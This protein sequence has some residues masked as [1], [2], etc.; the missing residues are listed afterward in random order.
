MAI[1]PCLMRSMNA[2][3]E[4]THGRGISNTCLKVCEAMERLTGVSINSTEQHVE[5]RDSHKRD[6]ETFMSLIKQHSPWTESYC[7]RSL[8]SGVIG[9]KKI[10]CHNALSDG[11][12]AMKTMIGSNFADVKLTRKN[13]V[14]PLTVVNKSIT[15]RNEVVPVNLQQLFMHIVWAVNNNAG[16]L[17]YYLKYE[18][19]PRPPALFDDVSMRKIAKYAF[20]DVFNLAPAPDILQETSAFIIDGGYLLRVLVWP[21]SATFGTVVDSYL[22]YVVRHYSA[23][24]IVVFD[25]YD[26]VLST[27]REERKRCSLRKTCSNKSF[28]SS[29]I[30]T[31]SQADFL[32]NGHNKARL[33]SMLSQELN[34]A[35]LKV[36][37]AVADADTLIVRTALQ[38]ATEG[39]ESIVVATDT[40]ILIMLLARSHEGT[41]IHSLSPGSNIYSVGDIQRQMDAKKICLLFVHA[42]TGCD[43]TSAVFGK[44]KKKAWK[45]L[46]KLS[47]QSIAEFFNNPSADKGQIITAGEQFL[48]QLHT[49][50]NLTSLDELRGRMYARSLAKEPVTA[51]F[52]HAALRSTSTASQQHNLCR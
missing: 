41:S 5:L 25:G 44:G 14:L 50:D 28:D 38:E 9:H 16:D 6:G 42:V 27:K 47:V 49:N 11:S 13:R 7:L 46:D 23:S 48:I 26:D 10:K 31:V 30:I 37:Q 29:T 3:G 36:H 39:R 2:Q 35:R 21:R 43:T 22:Q 19:T 4:L 1:E 33:I 34:H 45:L 24:A 20:L 15:I 12:A 40:D 17:L 32:S 8:S 52:E 51:S 18:L